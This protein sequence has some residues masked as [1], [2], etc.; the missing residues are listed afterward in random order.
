M[1]KKLAE[2]CSLIGWRI[3]I[4][5]FSLGE[6][7]RT[8]VYYVRNWTFCK[9]DLALHLLYL[10]KN[11]YRISKEFLSKRGEPL[12]Y[13]YGETP[14]STLEKIA[15]EG[16][17]SS[18]D[19]FFEMGSG[20]GRGCFWIHQFVHCRV[21]GIEYIPLFVERSNR[22]AKW[23]NLQDIQFIL[24]DWQ[25]LSYQ[26]ATFIYLYG[27]NMDEKEIKRLLSKLKELSSGTKVVTVS[28]SIPEYDRSSTFRVIKEF[29]GS[30]PWG[31]ASL[32]LNIKS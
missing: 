14:L 32:Y 31:K 26:E 17:L 1:I 28:W 16:E 27:S 22:L 29:E 11:P 18:S 10:F 8:L 20:R 24:S 7:P 2:Y 19:H 4:S 23:Q 13:A 15:K 25:D 3:R 30:Y 12:I 9:L 21:K 6:L 5:L